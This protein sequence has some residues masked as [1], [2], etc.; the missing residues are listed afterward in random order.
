MCCDKDMEPKSCVNDCNART[1]DSLK[2]TSKS[3][4][5]SENCYRD[6]CDCKNGLYLN[7]CNVCVPESRCG[8]PCK[9]TPIVCP[10]QNELLIPCFD[11][12][13]ARKCWNSANETSCTPNSPRDVDL[14]D[15]FDAKAWWPE[16]KCIM[17]VCDCLP[18]YYRNKCGICV[19]WHACDNPCVPKA[20]QPCSDPN[21]KR[22]PQWRECEERT[23]VNL[24][25]P[26]ARDAQTS[27]L[28]ENK[29]DCKPTYY[30]DNCGRCVPK[31][32]CED[33]R[34]CKCTNPC[35]VKNQ[36][37]RCINSC[38][39][40]TCARALDVPVICK[41]N[42]Y[43][44]CDCQDFFWLNKHGICVSK[45]ECTYHDIEATAKT[46]RN[47]DV[48]SEE[49]N[50]FENIFPTNGAFP[51]QGG[52]GGFPAQGPGGHGHKGYH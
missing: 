13:F 46:V 41:K 6:R 31:A 43:D 20:N 36:V 44:A 30:R 52:P 40:R 32:E 7:S 33:Q 27:Q 17:N 37:I 24:K 19:D 25:Y 42:C 51:G 10:G 3:Q 29:C 49:P 18:G 22:Y 15:T 50:V 34:P 16:G 11:P 8:E 1:C 38:T 48:K 35:K 28:Y 47:E 21:E 4:K 14:Y 12:G 5:C 2:K 39:K 9:G 45:E 26:M 23:C